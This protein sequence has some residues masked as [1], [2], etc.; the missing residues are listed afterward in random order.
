M[1]DALKILES[2]ELAIIKLYMPSCPPCK[3]MAPVL[4]A[5]AKE[6]GIPVVA[7][8]LKVK[9]FDRAAD[10]CGVDRT[11]TL[12]VIRDGREV[13]RGYPR[14]KLGLARLVKRAQRA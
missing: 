11:P 2:G 8:D 4:A 13:A 6:T 1:T 7:A 12:I 9:C 5:F 3:K 10:R 14:T